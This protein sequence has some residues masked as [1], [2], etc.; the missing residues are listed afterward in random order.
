MRE[1]LRRSFPEAS[2]RSPSP[3]TSSSM[4]VAASSVPC[5]VRTSRAVAWAITIAEAAAKRSAW[6]TTAL[7]AASRRSRSRSSPNASPTAAVR[8]AAPL[9]AEGVPARH[10]RRPSLS[11]RIASLDERPRC[12]RARAWATS[13]SPKAWAAESSPAMQACSV[14]L[15]V[16]ESSVWG[17]APLPVTCSRSASQPKR[18]RMPSGRMPLTWRPRADPQAAPSSAPSRRSTAGAGLEARAVAAGAGPAGSRP[19]WI[20]SRSASFMGEGDSWGEVAW[21]SDGGVAE[22]QGAEGR[23]SGSGEVSFKS[24]SRSGGPGRERSAAIDGGREEPGAKARGEL[25]RGCADTAPTREAWEVTRR[26]QGHR[27]RVRC[28]GPRG[29]GS[30]RVV[31]RE[32]VLGVRAAAWSSEPG[33]SRGRSSGL[34]GGAEPSNPTFV[35]EGQ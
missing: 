15:S 16:R 28:G 6:V 26:G 31:T 32:P 18:W 8:S 34:V 33:A 20:S 30:A 27:Q 1:R 13:R 12:C 3:A 14:R 2:S 22:G 23:G 35:S 4:N 17:Q 9:P 21:E 11:R 19:R 10:Q 25:R 7:R 5:G 24:G 29:L